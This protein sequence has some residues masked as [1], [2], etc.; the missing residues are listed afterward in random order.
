M[1]VEAGEMAW[2]TRREQWL[3]EANIAKA[4]AGWEDKNERL[5]AFA[6]G[7]KV[8]RGGS[9]PKEVVVVVV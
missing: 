7:I 9:Q 2:R 5:N 6:I 3:E 8:K 1:C 4:A